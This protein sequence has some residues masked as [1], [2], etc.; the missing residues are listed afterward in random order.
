M[1]QQTTPATQ[2]VRREATTSHFE[3]RCGKCHQWLPV[4]EYWKCRGNRTTDGLQGYCKT[5][6][7]AAVRRYTV[8]GV[9]V[10]RGATA[11]EKARRAKDADIDL[12]IWWVMRAMNPLVAD[13]SRDGRR[14]SDFMRCLEE[15]A[16]API[17]DHIREEFETRP[18]LRKEE[19]ADVA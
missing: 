11:A 13:R 4:T 17:P 12:R 1:R 5:C 6:L 18:W 7:K 2:S 9:Y 3:K 8:K 14:H 16:T 19:T 15:T 10:K